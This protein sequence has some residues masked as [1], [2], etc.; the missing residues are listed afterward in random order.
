MPSWRTVLRWITAPFRLPWQGIQ[1]LA[2]RLYRYRM[3]VVAFFTAE[4]ET[5]PLADVVQTSVTHP[6]ALWPHFVALR[7]HLLRAVIV[8]VLATAGA[9]VFTARLIAFLTAPIGGITQSCGAVP[10]SFF[11]S[12]RGGD[13]NGVRQDRSTCAGDDSERAVASGEA[14]EIQRICFEHR[15]CRSTADLDAGNQPSVG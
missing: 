13:T 12:V 15:T 4:P 1:A 9:F 11:K 10:A 2:R 5:H 6:K 8:W 7:R 3:K 14:G